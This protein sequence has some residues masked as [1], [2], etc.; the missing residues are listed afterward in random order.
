MSDDYKKS[1]ADNWRKFTKN[2]TTNKIQE[3]IQ[4][5]KENEK[6]LN[7]F[8]KLKRT[9]NTSTNKANFKPSELISPMFGKKN[10]KKIQNDFNSAKLKRSEDQKHIYKSV[11]EYID[12]KVRDQNVQ[13]K[14]PDW[15]KKTNSSEYQDTSE[16][17]RNIFNKIEK[18]NKKNNPDSGNNCLFD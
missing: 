16:H 14:Y 18:N 2:S 12:K 7:P 4:K 6:Y 10:L 17:H 1:Q 5:N 11:D 15:A 13:H 9:G 3:K 8:E